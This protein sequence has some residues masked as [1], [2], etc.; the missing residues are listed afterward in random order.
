[1]GLSLGC[2]MGDGHHLLGITLA[3]P[4]EPADSMYTCVHYACVS[5]HMHFKDP[6]H[7][8]LLTVMI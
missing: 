3:Y 8:V 4:P 1:M 5:S 2:H 6:L 7:R